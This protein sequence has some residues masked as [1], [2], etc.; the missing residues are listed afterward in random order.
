MEERATGQVLAVQELLGLLCLHDQAAK[1]FSSSKSAV[2]EIDS[3]EQ[4]SSPVARPA[5]AGSTVSDHSGRRAASQP[6]TH[7]HTHT[8]SGVITEACRRAVNHTEM[9]HTH[10]H[11]YI[12]IYTHRFTHTHST[13]Q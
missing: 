2:Q 11:T 6:H 4:A 7:T 5:L 3:E 9:L 8:H 13:G 1:M 12:Y 10:T